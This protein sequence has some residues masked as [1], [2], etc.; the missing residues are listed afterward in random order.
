MASL[1][2]VEYDHDS[3]QL[4]HVDDP[5]ESEAGFTRLQWSIILD[6]PR[7]LLSSLRPPG[8]MRRFVASIIGKSVNLTLSN[9][10]LEALRRTALLTWHHGF[11]LPSN[12][13]SDFLAAGFTLKQFEMMIGALRTVTGPKQKFAR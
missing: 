9:P 10:H 3:P 2:Q 7:D 8:R 1:A 11:K 13:L 4:A 5:I 6:A 12:E